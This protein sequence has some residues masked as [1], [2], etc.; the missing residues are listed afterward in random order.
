M[1][2]EFIFNQHKGAEW[3]DWKENGEIKK[4]LR[5]NNTLKISY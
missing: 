4:N 3:K 2:K 5:R 1:T